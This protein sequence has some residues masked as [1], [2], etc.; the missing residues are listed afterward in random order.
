MLPYRTLDNIIEG[1]V[2]TFID[3]SERK[4]TEE[5]LKDALEDIR[6]LRGIIPICSN[7]KKIR[8]DK[9]FW[10]QVES[11]ISSHSP[12]VFSHGICPDCLKKEFPDYLDDD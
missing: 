2:I 10:N 11:Y 4:K 1:A 5:A 9:G 3:I 6:T 12:A 7:C 8:D